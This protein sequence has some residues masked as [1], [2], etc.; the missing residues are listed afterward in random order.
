MEFDEMKKIWDAQNGQTLYAID[1]EAL[2]K[3]VL[4]KRNKAAKLASIT[5]LM[6]IS[7]LLFSTSIIMAAAIYKSKYDLMPM[8]MAVLMLIAAVMIYMRRNKRLSWQNNFENSILGD[9]NQAVANANYQVKLSHSVKW[10]LLVVALFT[11]AGVI[12]SGAEWWKGALVGLF[13]I[14]VYYASRWEYRTFYVSQKKGLE[15]MRD[16]LIALQDDGEE[17]SDMDGQL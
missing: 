4:N 8:G 16:K 15:K 2:H 6:I 14:I 10:F 17:P 5:E 1:E 13:F 12:E 11:T 3:R 7:A 9:V